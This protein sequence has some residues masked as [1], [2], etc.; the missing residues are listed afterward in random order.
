MREIALHLLDIARNAVEADATCIRITLREADGWLTMTVEDDGH[1]MTPAFAA[2]ATDPFA[3]TRTTRRVGMGLALLRQATELT[4]GGLT[5]V[6]R[7]RELC[8]EDQ[9]TTVTATFC[10]LHIDCPPVGDMAATLW[11]LVQ[12]APQVDWVFRHETPERVVR[13]DTRELRVALG[14]DIPLCEPAVLDWLGGY[15]REQ[16]GRTD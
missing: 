8:P 15:L 2:R 10:R 16:Y 12:G 1:G 3:T 9:G 11:T 4:G 7:H 5:L 13:L 6:S 14:E